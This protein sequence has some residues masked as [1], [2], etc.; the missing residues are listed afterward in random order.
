M[1]PLP[2]SGETPGE[3]EDRESGGFPQV[4]NKLSLDPTSVLRVAS[5]ITYFSSSLTMKLTPGSQLVDPKKHIVW[6]FDNTAYQPAHGPVY[7]P[8]GWHAHVVGCM[9]EKHGRQDIGRW[10]AIIADL[11]GLDGNPG[12]DKEAVRKRIAMRIQPFLNAVVP[13]RFIKLEVPISSGEVHRF[14]L[15]SSNKD[16]ISEDDIRIFPAAGVHDGTV[17]QSQARNWGPKPLTMMTTFAA[18]ESWAVIS[19]VDDTI[20]YTQ[21]PDAIGILRTTFVDDPKAIAGMPEVYTHIQ[22]QLNPTWFYLSA[23]PYNLYEFLH[24]FLRST[25]PRGT[26]LL[27]EGSWMDL[28]GLLRSFSQGTQEYKVSQLDKVFGWFPMRKVL[29]IGDSTQSDPEAYAEAYKKHDGWIKAIYIRKVTD[30]GNMGDRNDP[31]RFEKAFEG[32]PRSVWRVFEHADEL[33][34]LVD[35]LKSQPS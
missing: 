19:D 4:E 23:S 6:L 5:W 2:G 15:G 31:E 8:I 20:K 21:T 13:N 29:C 1:T 35:E 32:I 14:K 9:F 28:A 3:R 17:V 10:V 24:G 30:V 18:Q 12:L 22:Q 16:G 34:A 7:G 27:R 25:F 11:V 33:S 26:L